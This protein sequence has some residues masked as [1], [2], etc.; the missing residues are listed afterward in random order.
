MARRRS[1]QRRPMSVP[2]MLVGV[3]WYDP[4]QWAKLKQVA[5]D[6]D[7]L[8]ESHEA[9]LRMAERALQDLTA[10][11]LDVRRVPLNVD[12][13]VQWCRD[14]NKVIDGKA[15][16]EYTSLIINGRISG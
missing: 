14:H 13:L 3:A 7:R 5:A 16:A 1:K 8:E 15:R 11:G 9:W 10:Q 2:P 6:S 4:V 12:A